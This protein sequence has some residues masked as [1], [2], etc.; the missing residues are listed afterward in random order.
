MTMPG[1]PDCPLDCDEPLFKEGHEFQ[2]PP[3]SLDSDAQ[4]VAAV[5]LSGPFRNY[6]GVFVPWIMETLHPA[7]AG[8]RVTAACCVILRS[9]ATKNLFHAAYII[10]FM[11]QCNK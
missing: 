11:K 3:D 8:F 5:R 10:V 1:H 4:C 9:E 7:T 2:A 6:G